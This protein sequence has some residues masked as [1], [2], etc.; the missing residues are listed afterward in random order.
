MKNIH[1]LPKEEPKTTGDIVVDYSIAQS[2]A[3]QKC[4]HLDAE[5]AYKSLS[6]QETLENIKQFEDCIRTLDENFAQQETLE[7][8]SKRAVK[9]GLFKDETLFTAGAKWQ[10]EQDKNKYSEEEVEDLIYKVC[11][12]VARLQGITLNGN[13]INAAFEQFKKK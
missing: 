6:K 5:M 12:T 4:M 13:N 11:G 2:K 1:V 3:I 10:Q 7:E 9:S 8:A